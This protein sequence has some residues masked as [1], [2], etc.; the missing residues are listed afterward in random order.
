ML[1]I[2][3]HCV[4]KC[5]EVF[6]AQILKC[7]TCVP[8]ICCMWG[9]GH[10]WLWRK[11]NSENPSI[12]HL[13]ITECKGL[14]PGCSHTAVNTFTFF[15]LNLRKLNSNSI[16]VM[17]YRPGGPE[18]PGPARGPGAGGAG[19]SVHHHHRDILRGGRGW[20]RVQEGG[21]QGK[22]THAHAHVRRVQVYKLSRV[23]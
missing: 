14:Q 5:P 12:A 6:A 20:P 17:V 9:F 21:P 13:L 18:Q 23:Y 11:T 19:H 2:N 8:F 7:N 10:P 3:T 22:H 16:C 15:F 4:Q 1:Q